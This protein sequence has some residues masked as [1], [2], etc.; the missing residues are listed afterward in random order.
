MVV[1]LLGKKYSL[2]AWPIVYKSQMHGGLGV[3]DL[4]LMNTSLL[5]KWYFRFHNS[6]EQ[7]IWKSILITK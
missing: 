1:I 3:L 5:A 2:V 6:Q 4:E 7:G